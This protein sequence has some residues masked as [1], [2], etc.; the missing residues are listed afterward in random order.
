MTPSLHPPCLACAGPAP[1]CPHPRL[2]IVSTPPPPPPLPPPLRYTYLVAIAD[3]V[4][5]LH[6]KTSRKLM[7][8][9]EKINY[10]TSWRQRISIYWMQEGFWYQRAETHHWLLPSIFS[11]EFSFQPAQH[12]RLCLI[13]RESSSRHLSHEFWKVHTLFMLWHHCSLN[14]SPDTRYIWYSLWQQRQKGWVQF[15]NV[16]KSLHPSLDREDAT[17]ITDQANCLME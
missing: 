5:P 9:Q 11:V 17:I 8:K 7:S 16:S 10:I 1:L 3:D 13:F 12:R 14:T 6:R 4:H 15:W 2:S